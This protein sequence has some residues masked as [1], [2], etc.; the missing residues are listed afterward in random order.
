MNFHIST[1]FIKNFN[2]FLSKCIGLIVVVDIT[3]CTMTVHHFMS[4]VKLSQHV[5]HEVFDEVSFWPKDLYLGLS[6]LHDSDKMVQ[7]HIFAIQ[8]IAFVFHIDD[9]IAKTLHGIRDAHQVSSIFSSS[10][11][12]ISNHRSIFSFPSSFYLNFILL[13]CFSSLMF[14]E[15]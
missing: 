6:F 1:T 7:I 10:E 8:G 15:L 12:S 4:W 13:T 14:W 2:S 3:E 9:S 5:R 11:L